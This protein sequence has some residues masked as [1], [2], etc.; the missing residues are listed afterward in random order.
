VH[1]AAFADVDAG[2]A[3]AF[4]VKNLFNPVGFGSA[5]VGAGAAGG[6]GAL[7]SAP[8]TEV[9]DCCDC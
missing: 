3:A 6:G 4:L 1:V 7:L 2:F 9:F 8:A 5:G